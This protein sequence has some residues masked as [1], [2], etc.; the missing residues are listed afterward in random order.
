MIRGRLYVPYLKMFWN[1]VADLIPCQLPIYINF[2]IFPE[3]QNQ[4]KIH[5]KLLCSISDNKN[6]MLY[7]VNRVESVDCFVSYPKVYQ[8]FVTEPSLKGNMN[9]IT[10]VLRGTKMCSWDW[11]K[12]QVCLNIIF[13][14]WDIE[15]WYILI[16]ALMMRW[17]D[18]DIRIICVAF[19]GD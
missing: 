6:L 12:F 13:T 2:S 9:G 3:I 14:V 15:M 4:L 11:C 10:S 5:S 7:S 19:G 16:N 18:F 8:H 1:L 17:D